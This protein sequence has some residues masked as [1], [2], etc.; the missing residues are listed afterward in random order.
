MNRIS[1]WIWI[2]L[3]TGMFPFLL[4]AQSDSTDTILAVGVVTVRQS[5]EIG[6]LYRE[7]VRTNEGSAIQ[8]YRI[9]IF[10]GNKKG[11]FD[12]K[13]AFL[14]S[15]LDLPV[16]I[17]YETPEYKTQIGNFRTRLDAERALKAVREVDRGAFVVK[18]RI[19]LP[20]LPK[21]EKPATQKDAGSDKP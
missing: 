12:A 2:C 13:S 15:G 21:K 18:T 8:G 20:D 6:Q 11:A 3:L 1:I 14:R 9:Q 4:A 5:P 7:W 16:N 19:D 10:N 17:I